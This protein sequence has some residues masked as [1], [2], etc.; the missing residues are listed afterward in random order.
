MKTIK[1]TNYYPFGL[2]MAGISSKAAGKLENKKN[3]FQGQEYNDDLGVDMYEFK[4]RM[5]DPQTG[6]FW[7]VDP[8]AEKY[9]YNSTYAFS[10]NKVTGH[11]ELEGLE[12]LSVNDVSNIYLRAAFKENVQNTLQSLRR[13]GSEAVQVKGTVGVGVGVSGGVGKLKGDASVNGPQVEASINGGGN[14]GAKGSMAG[15]GVKGEFSGGEVKAGVNAGV[16]QLKDGK[17]SA[18]VVTAGIGADITASKTNKSGELSQSMGG[19]LL[20]ATVTVGAKVGL[21]GVEVSLNVYKAGAAVVDFFKAGAEWMGN[22]VKDMAPKAPS[23][24]PSQK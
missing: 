15:A 17:V 14:V 4:Y 5:D 22:V 18:D 9:V 10:E 20:D 21:A 1:S 11:I 12:S 23:L 16:V 7:Q 13:N 8:L 3:K 19:K 2:A 6:R 24:D